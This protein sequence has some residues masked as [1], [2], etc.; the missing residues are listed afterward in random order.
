VFLDAPHQLLP[1]KPLTVW[2]LVKDA[3]R[4][5]V[6]VR[7]VRFRL[8]DAS[9]RSA[10]QDFE[11]DA[12]CAA[13]LQHLA[14]PLSVVGF[15]GD[16]RVEGEIRLENARGQGRLVRNHNYP[17]ITP[18]PLEI[19]LL[20]SPLPY[21]SGWRAGELHCHSEFTSDHV[22]FGAP[23][24]LM[25]EAADA[26]GLDFVL[27][28]DHSYDFPY[29][30]DRYLEPIDGAQN[31]AEYR[32]QASALNTA[33]PELPTLVAGEEISCGNARGQN[34]H[35]LAFG[36][37]EF[38]P[39]NGDGGRHGLRNRPDLS[40]GEVLERLGD[41]PAFAAHPAGHKG[42]M[43]RL[44]LRRGP[45]RAEDVRPDTSGRAVRGLQFWNGTLN[46]E[47]REGKAL[48]VDELLQGR[49]P[50]PIGANDAHG[51]FNRNVWVKTPLIALRETRSHLFG[52][53]RT[54]APCEGRD[55]DSLK[56][57]F[58]G[59]ECVCTDGP[60]A[61]LSVE[62]GMLRVAA[63]STR[64]FGTLSSVTVLG[65]AQGDRAERV[66]ASWDFASDGPLRVEES[67]ALPFPAGRKGYARLEVATTRGR[68]ALTAARSLE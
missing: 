49:R 32:G 11:P 7:S 62:Y 51:D 67:V 24:A 26:V 47:Y 10:T 6:R 58:R 25:Q 20:E 30:R 18:T 45:W 48:W 22:E 38:I 50:L 40:I 17:G 54:L 9:G 61:A 64:D 12:R 66:L 37:P 19:R 42:R 56:N 31:Y 52:R 55:A 14:F 29:R 41:T 13:H 36:H 35:L 53:V 23:L 5:P 33:R 3:D 15:Q 16:L 2:L 34:V 60:F 63:E 28:T 57:A 39:G 4:F 43:E 59:P 21:P 8:W 1:G 65:A 27:C 44:I 46:T 68:R